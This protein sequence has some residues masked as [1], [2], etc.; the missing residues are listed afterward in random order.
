MVAGAVAAYYAEHP[1]N[2]EFATFGDSLWW[3]LS[4]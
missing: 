4:P 1:V 3:R 2:P